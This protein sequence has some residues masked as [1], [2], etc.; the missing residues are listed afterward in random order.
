LERQIA[1]RFIENGDKLEGYRI[2]LFR[3]KQ[4]NLKAIQKDEELIK[5]FLEKAKE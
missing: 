4:L 2:L 1:K 5:Q 3:C